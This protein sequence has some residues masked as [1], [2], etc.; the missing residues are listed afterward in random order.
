VEESGGSD[1]GRAAA[2]LDRYDQDKEWQKRLAG[3]CPPPVR[4]IP[5]IDEYLKLL[6]DDDEEITRNARISLDQ[7]HRLFFRLAV[8]VLVL[9]VQAPSFSSYLNCFLFKLLFLLLHLTIFF[10]FK[11]LKLSDILLLYFIIKFF[12][13]NE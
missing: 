5:E 4:L 3:R 12:E 8:L 6:D 7:R 10:I 13:K 1:A 2:K 11:K 9:A